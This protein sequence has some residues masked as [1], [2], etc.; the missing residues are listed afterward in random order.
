MTSLPIHGNGTSS[1]VDG[2]SEAKKQIL[3]NAFDMSTVGHLSPG[4]WKPISAMAA[5]TKNLSF[6]IT[7]STSFEPPFLLAKRFSSLDHFTRGRIGWNIVTSWKKSA[8]KAIGID[9]PTPHDERYEQADEYL[10]VL[11]NDERSTTA[12]DAEAKYFRVVNSSLSL[13]LELLQ[14]LEQ[15]DLDAEADSYDIFFSEDVVWKSATFADSA[16][17]KV[18]C[19]LL[20][21]CLEKRHDAVASQ[22]SRLKKIFVTE[23]LKSNQTGSAVEYVRV[24]TRLTQ[25][26]PEIWSS[27]SDKKTPISRLQ[28][29]L[30]KGSQGSSVKFWGYLEQLLA[31]LPTEQLTYES[32]SDILRSLRVGIASRGEPRINAPSAWTCYVR[33]ARHFLTLLPSDGPQSQFLLDHIFPLI[34]H[35]LKPTTE[36]T[37]WDVGGKAGTPVLV[38]AFGI[39]VDRHLEGAQ[40]ETA[41]A[42]QRLSSEF[43]SKISSSLPEVSKDYEKSQDA[44]AQEGDRWFSLVGQ[45]HT[46]IP[47]AHQKAQ[48]L[49]RP[50]KD[51]VFRAIELLANRNLKPYGAASVLHSVGRYASF[52]WEDKSVSTEFEKFLLE[53]GRDHMDLILASRS[54]KDLVACVSGLGASQ[55]Q[56]AAFSTIWKTWV[57]T[58]ILQQE[59]PAALEAIGSLATSQGGITFASSHAGYQDLL[60]AK[61]SQSLQGST[62]AWSFLEEAFIKETVTDR[63]SE[64]IVQEAL[65]LLGRDKQ[66]T[67]NAVRALEIIASRNSAQLSRDDTTHMAL[68]TSLLGLA[69]LDD[70]TISS[71]A[72]TLRSLIDKPSGG[73]Q[74]AVAI[75]Q[76]NLED[77]NQQSLG[78]W[79]SRDPND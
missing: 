59:Q 16:V 26:F 25:K 6:A 46:K 50:S 3:L 24:L 5:V 8:F 1:P 9:S 14:K 13:V 41:D 33:A 61:A 58:L 68:I 17:R 7:A 64:S 52:I 31:V 49:D 74:A 10:R 72:N 53:Q 36:T 70:S 21:T 19:E 65:T 38:E 62:D 78:F 11:Y 54:R 48:V 73:K 60:A 42:W 55:N 30:E 66:Q 40:T 28:L 77:A 76:R 75:I 71:R 45:I 47:A 2:P 63:V 35:Y 43:C 23:G 29:F 39:T 32:A 18:T 51:I 20:W 44:V 12:D 67:D 27:S 57:D 37:G 34:S 22:V 69:E 4:Q 15:A 56:H 79:L